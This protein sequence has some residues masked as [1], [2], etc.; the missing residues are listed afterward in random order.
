MSHYILSIDQSTQGTKG[1]LF[2]ENGILIA[3]ADKSHRQI[4]NEFG[5]VG[6]DPMEILQNTLAV[7]RRVTEKAGIPKS[8]IKAAAISNQRETSMMWDRETGKPLDHAIVWQCARAKEICERPEFAAL[9]E[10]FQEKTGLNLSPYFPAPK[11]TW[12]M[13][14]IPEARILAKKGRLCCGTIDSWLVYCLTNG[15]SFKTDYSNASRTGLY[16]IRNL[17]W[18]EELCSAFQVP[19]DAL[20]EVCMSDSN[21]GSTTLGGWLDAPIPIHG[22]LGDSHGALFGQDCR[23]PGQAKVTYGTGSSVMMN[24]GTEPRISKKG[25]VTSLAWGLNGRIEYVFEGNLNYTGAVITWLRQDL[26]LIRTDQEATKRAYEANPNDRTYFVPAFT[27]LGA[28][29][30]D[31]HATGMFTGITRTTRRNEIAKACLDCIAYQISDLTDLMSEESGFPLSTL[32][33]DGGPTASSYLMQFQSDIARV[34]V[35]IPDIQEL[36]GMGA[37]YAAG[38]A[39]GLYNADTIYR[40]I[41]RKEYAPEMSPM[42]Q[43][44]LYA[45]WKHAVRQTLHHL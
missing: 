4:I 30:W 40:H 42:Q 28:P 13:E 29:Y 1:L 26:G 3:R 11:F 36:S 23:L 32:R 20:P 34:K 8:D 22:I 43:E 17:K 7:C 44:Q 35:Q 6:H 39:I 9:S 18:D 21:F 27:G 15:R 25:L 19:P 10:S 37:A 12:L 16:H 33:A 31:S 2:D 14:Q 24:L 5:W 38:I 41:Q 45:G